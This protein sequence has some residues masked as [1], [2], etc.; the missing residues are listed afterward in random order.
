MILLEAPAVT[1]SGR[2]VAN[3]G[4][5]GGGAENMPGIDGSPGDSG[6]LTTVRATGG[7]G[8]L[9]NEGGTGGGGGAGTLLAGL[10][11]PSTPDNG[12]GGGGGGVGYI[13]VIGASTTMGSLISPPLTPFP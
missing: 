5:G 12:G 1:I 2:L 11:S 7:A 8:A 9:I 4:G 10:A 6:G 13:S 3:G